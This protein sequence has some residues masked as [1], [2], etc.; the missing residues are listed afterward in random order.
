MGKKRMNRQYFN[1]KSLLK[2]PE[3]PGVYELIGPRNK[4]KYVG[5]ANNLRRRLRQHLNQRDVQGTMGFRVRFAPPSVA[6]KIENRIIKKKK[7]PFN[8]RLW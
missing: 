6:E 2:V 3:R 1:K 5:K 4:T 8:E 7:P